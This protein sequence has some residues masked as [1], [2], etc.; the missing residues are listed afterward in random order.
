MIPFN[1]ATV[2]PTQLSNLEECFASGHLSGDGPFSA[3]A[4]AA[5][6]ELHDGAAVLLTPSC[7]A[8]LELSA[9]LLELQP[10][11][12]VIVPSFTFPSTA[13]AF[14][15]MGARIVFADIERTTLGLDPQQLEQLITP[16][17]RAVVPV[18]Y[19][20][21]PVSSDVAE[22]ARRHDVMVIDDN[23]HGLFAK[24]DGRPLGTG[25]ALSTLSFHNTKNVTCGEGGALVINDEALHERA[26][27]LREKGTDRARFFRGMVD[28][29]SWVDIGSSYLLADLNAA[30]LLAQLDFAGEIQRRRHDAWAVYRREL[31]PWADANGVEIV[32]PPADL[33]P[34]AH[35]FALLMPDLEARTSFIDHAKQGGVTASFHYVPLHSSTA[36]K[37]AGTAPLG[38]PVSDEISD[39]LVRLPMF[40]DIRP[41]E[42]DRVV[43]VVGAWT[44]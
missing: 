33:E 25:G 21:V 6:S 40:S 38:C 3:A 24:Q 14:A 23:A 29:Y 34:A 42:V 9:L 17:T 16:R 44:R 15:L 1:R 20:G 19:G 10:G 31:G 36:G 18:N 39:R 7:T 35:M 12:E 28:K 13:G 8:A 27:I 22:I 4:T 26:E 41:D 37:R 30:M 5:L 43:E 11:D 32:D 2:A